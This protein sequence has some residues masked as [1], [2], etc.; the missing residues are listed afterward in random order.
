MA[1]SAAR[2]QFTVDPGGGGGSGP[3]TKDACALMPPDF[4]G[5]AAGTAPRRT[6][7]GIR[8][9]SGRWPPRRET[10]AR[11]EAPPPR[12]FHQT[13]LRIVRHEWDSLGWQSS[14][15]SKVRPRY[16]RHGARVRRRLA[17]RRRTPSARRRPGLGV[18]RVMPWPPDTSARRRTGPTTDESPQPRAL[19]A[20][21]PERSP[22]APPCW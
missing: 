9:D 15:D 11:A 12:R 20:F 3:E 7:P 16:R 17:S 2:F 19:R 8:E 6:P 13:S 5:G 22:T 10:G 14:E 1:G 21:L 18:M 4:G